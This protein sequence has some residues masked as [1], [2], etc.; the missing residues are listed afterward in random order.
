MID[1]TWVPLV[2]Y[3]RNGVPEVTV[4]GAVAWFKG[5]KPYHSYGGNV[6]CYGRSMMKPV[7]IKVIAKELD[8]HLSWESK[9][10]SIASHN[11]EPIHIEAVR[12]ILKPSE[13]GLLQTPHSLP[14][15]QFGKQL[16]RPRRWYHSCSGKHAAILRACAINHWARIGYTLPQHPFHQVYVAKVR[17]ILGADLQSSVFAKDGCGLPTLAMTVNELAA[18]FA[19]LA[20]RKDEDWI[21]EAMIRHPDHIGGFN[22]LDSTILKSCGGRVIA[23]EGADGLLGLSILHPDYPEG[24]GVVIKMSHGWDP[25]ATWYVARWVLGVLGFELRNPYPLE[26]QKAFIVEEIIPPDLRKN[27]SDVK[28]WDDWDPDQ[29][30]WFYNPDSY[31]KGWQD[32]SDSQLY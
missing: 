13:Y 10:V 27:M 15:M 1:N 9:A 16:R 20:V 32:G 12:D 28:P 8:P 22:R 30:R 24:L 21:W 19:D 4:H 23:K 11:A 6:L 7:Q 14:L 26:R 31:V 29:D 17:E 5:K 25:R 2:D 3:R 18:L